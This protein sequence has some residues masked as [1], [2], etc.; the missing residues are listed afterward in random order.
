MGNTDLEISRIGLGAWAIGGVWKWGWGSQSDRDSRDTINR[1]LDAGI[2]WI[3]TAAIYG[4][5][6]SE[7]VIGKALKKRGGPKPLLFTKCGQIWDKTSQQT[8]SLK[9]ESIFREV[10]QSLKRL[11]CDVIDL[12][13]IHW[14]KPDEEIEEGWEALLRLKEQGKIRW[15]GVSNFSVSQLERI[16]AIAPVFSL[17][18]PY[19]L[20]RREAEAEILPWCREHGTGVIVYSPMGSGLLSGAMTRERIEAMDITDW[21]RRSDAFTGDRLERNLGLQALCVEIGRD[22]GCT[23]GA[24]AVAWTLKNPAVTAAIVGMRKPEQVAD[25]VAAAELTLSEE[26]I[27]RQE[28]EVQGA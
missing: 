21:R 5:G 19:S 7:E 8:V 3:D 24:V 6:H 13:Q 17:Q 16:A 27:R 22:H 1:A 15:G 12:Y 20:I 23:A 18:P 9:R 28:A 14:P 26:D 11:Q 2:N 4:M 25:L 10:D